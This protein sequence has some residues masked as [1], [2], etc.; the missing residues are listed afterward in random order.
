MDIEINGIPTDHENVYL[1]PSEIAGIGLF[2]KKSFRRGDYICGYSGK[3][4]STNVVKRK[5]YKSDYV[6]EINEVW[7]ID[8]QEPN[9]SYG[10]YAND[11]IIEPRTKEERMLGNG[12]NS[13]LSCYFDERAPEDVD[14][15]EA[16]LIAKYDI[17]KDA[18][19]L[20]SYGSSYWNNIEHFSILSEDRQLYLKQKS[21]K[22]VKLY[23][24]THIIDLTDETDD[25]METFV[26]GISV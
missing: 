18:E 19:I 7:S 2:S 23:R 11:Y 25:D 15:I 10:R 17:A 22:Y 1:F 4:V 9:S 8:G 24:Q 14:K 6:F 21:K 13:E 3:F 20:C 26:N 5:T 16:F 12:N